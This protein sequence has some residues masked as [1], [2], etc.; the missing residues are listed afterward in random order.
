[1][2]SILKIEHTNGLWLKPWEWAAVLAVTLIVVWGVLPSWHARYLKIDLPKDF[3]LSY[4]L[5]DDY[6][7]YRSV[8]AKAVESHP[9]LFIGDS[10]VWGMYVKNDHTLPAILNAKCGG[11]EI[12]NLAVDG[13][14]PVVMETLVRKYGKD[15][16]DRVV[17]VYLNPLWMTSPLYDLSGDG[18]LA[19]NHPRLLPQFAGKP[20]CY[21]VSFD[22]RC[23]AVWERMIDFEAL[24]HHVR[25]AFLDNKDVK[26]HLA[27]QPDKPLCKQLS[28]NIEPLEA[29]HSN[30]SKITWEDAGIAEQDWPWV[31]LDESRQWRSYLNTLELLKKRGNT[32][33]AVVGTVNPFMQTAASLEKYHA[34]RADVLKRLKDA[35]YKTVDLPELPSEEYGDASHPLAAGYERLAEFMMNN[36][37]LHIQEP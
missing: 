8:A 20:A 14:H 34:L 32:V 23:K 6:L 22:D 18:E 37:S 25:V 17:Y 33:I 10:V 27:K 15:I 3:R 28:L 13:L 35:G 1:M 29:G 24:L 36:H 16:C 5:R 26:N 7:L 2:K 12:G 21:H 4:K 9:A 11:E 30:D 19:I 31:P